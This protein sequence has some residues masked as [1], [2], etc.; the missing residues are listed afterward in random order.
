MTTV[1]CRPPQMG[2]QI[3]MYKFYHA[4]IKFLQADSY[5]EDFQTE[6]KDREN[7]MGKMIE[8]RAHMNLQLHHKQ[9]E[10]DQGQMAIASLRSDFQNKLSTL[11]R[12][13]ETSEAALHQNRLQLK[14]ARAQFEASMRQLQTE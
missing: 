14:E 5:K 13:F 4:R 2:L 10:V 11:S 1:T 7:A 12:K 6:R 9:D 3:H 8:E